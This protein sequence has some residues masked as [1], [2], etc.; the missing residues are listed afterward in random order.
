[1]LCLQDADKY[2]LMFMPASKCLA[3]ESYDSSPLQ[4]YVELSTINLNKKRTAR[5]S[6]IWS[7]MDTLKQKIWICGGSF[8]VPMVYP[9]GF[10]PYHA[11]NHPK[12]QQSPP[13]QIQRGQYIRPTAEATQEQS[14]WP[15]CDQLRIV[16]GDLGRQNADFNNSQ[17]AKGVLVNTLLKKV[18]N[19]TFQI[20]S[21]F[22]GII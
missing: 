20:V 7:K 11:P 4:L 15:I 2:V 6:K 12:S 22:L 19:D 5:C 9:N 10:D 17:P 18:V 1:M 16:K 21:I 13:V 14:P 3:C 8:W